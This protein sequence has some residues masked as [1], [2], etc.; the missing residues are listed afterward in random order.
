[1]AALASLSKSATSAWLGVSEI[2]LLLFGVLL[3]VGLVGEYRKSLSR[4]VKLF[5]MFVIIGVAGELLADGGIFA[6]SRHLETIANGEIAVLTEQAATANQH[7]A[8]ANDRAAQA[9]VLAKGFE[10]QIATAG[11]NAARANQKAESERLARTQ[12][13][14]KMRPRHL[15]AEQ[16]AKLASLLEDTPVPISIYSQA[17]DGESGDYADD[18]TAAFKAA[19]WQTLGPNQSRMTHDHGIEIGTLGLGSPIVRLMLEKIQKSFDEIGV[20]ARITQFRPDDQSMA[21]RFE[22]NVLYLIIDHKEDI[23]PADAPK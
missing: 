15:T 14:N 21:G 22:N 5:E 18:F 6:L 23:D 17:L 13:E 3:V 9:E 4:W 1:V 19:K 2:L 20:S 8:E 11:S 16:L 7:A 12:L 10:A